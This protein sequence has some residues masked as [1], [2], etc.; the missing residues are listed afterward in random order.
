MTDLAEGLEAY[1]NP[2]KF[3]QW[4]SAQIKELNH[5]WLDKDE[6]SQSFLAS[7][8]ERIFDRFEVKLNI[9]QIVFYQTI[10]RHAYIERFGALVQN[11]IK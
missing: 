10:V 6:L 11:H 2:N 7:F 5:V 1:P 8:L 9:N 4:W 3:N